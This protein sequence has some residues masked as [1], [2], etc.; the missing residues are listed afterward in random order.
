MLLLRLENAIDDNPPVELAAHHLFDVCSFVVMNSPS[1]FQIKLLYSW[2]T[3]SIQQTYDSQRVIDQL[4]SYPAC[5]TDKLHRGPFPK[6][7]YG[8][9]FIVFNRVQL[10][11]RP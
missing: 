1:D 10:N 4:D 8:H 7:N 6:S 9:K 2:S 11:L 5:I 3:G